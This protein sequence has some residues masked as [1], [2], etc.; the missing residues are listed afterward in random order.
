M[1]TIFVPFDK[2]HF[3]TDR[4]RRKTW[5]KKKRSL[6]I[7]EGDITFCQ[8]TQTH[9]GE[10]TENT[11]THQNQKLPGCHPNPLQTERLHL[12]KLSFS[13]MTHNNRLRLLSKIS[14]T[15]KTHA[16]FR[17]QMQLSHLWPQLH[18][19]CDVTVRSSLLP[20]QRPGHA[21]GDPPRG[22][23]CP[24][25]CRKLDQVDGSQRQACTSR[26]ARSRRS[27]GRAG[28]ERPDSQSG[29]GGEN[30][31]VSVKERWGACL[32]RQWHCG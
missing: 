24:Q 5:K 23:Q 3:A 30:R 4:G 7:P 13:V 6:L 1:K 10:H 28:S 9:T 8:Y 31:G 22:S 27:P 26:G 14:F 21:G 25:E 18:Q 19:M 20:G 15:Q 32:Q 17:E 29:T 2:V 12:E 11:P 16:I